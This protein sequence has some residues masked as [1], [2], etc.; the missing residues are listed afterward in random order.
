[1]Y[2]IEILNIKNKESVKEIAEKAGRS[3]SVVYRELKR[4][5]SIYRNRD[6]IEKEIYVPE[7]AHQMY[8]ENMKL[9]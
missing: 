4:D 1:M 3:L 5:R 6:Y 9:R 2:Q 8:R 7:L